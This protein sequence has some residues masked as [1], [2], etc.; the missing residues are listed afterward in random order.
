M[1]RIASIVIPSDDPERCGVG[2]RNGPPP[3]TDLQRGIP[4]CTPTQPHSPV[5][6]NAVRNPSFFSSVSIPATF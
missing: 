2:L 3:T 5:I 4:L 1:I 6:P